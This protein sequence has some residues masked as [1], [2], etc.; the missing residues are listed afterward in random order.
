MVRCLK[1]VDIL[2]VDLQNVLQKNNQRPT[3]LRQDRCSSAWTFAVGNI[4]VL[5]HV[6]LFATR[7]GCG[8]KG[9]LDNLPHTTPNILWISPRALNRADSVS[10]QYY[11]HILILTPY[12]EILIF[13]GYLFAKNMFKYVCL[14]ETRFVTYFLGCKTKRKLFRSITQMWNSLTFGILDWI[15]YEPQW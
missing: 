6:N 2:L 12:F 15:Q 1:T 8:T 5:K 9:L 3:Q 14:I 7:S 13:V 11:L 4:A 10:S